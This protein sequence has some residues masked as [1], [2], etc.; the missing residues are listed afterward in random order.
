MKRIYGKSFLAF[1]LSI[2]NRS[3]PTCLRLEDWCSDC[4]PHAYRYPRY[5]PMEFRDLAKL[6]VITCRCP[7]NGH[8]S[9]DLCNLWSTRHE[10]LIS[11]ATKSPDVLLHWLQSRLQ[12]LYGRHDRLTQGLSGDGRHPV[13][14]TFSSDQQVHRRDKIAIVQ[15][16]H[17]RPAERFRWL[18]GGT[19]LMI[20][21]T[22]TRP[23]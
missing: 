15:R 16:S 6:G 2:D 3:W 4:I 8:S 23:L 17:Q 12:N 18:H 22:N 7:V 19:S 11:P 21:S 1:L 14:T 13:Y 10:H 9:R 20:L 5:L